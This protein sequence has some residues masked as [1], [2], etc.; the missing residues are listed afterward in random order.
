MEKIR[1]KKIDIPLSA[2]TIKGRPTD[3]DMRVLTPADKITVEVAAVDGSLDVAGQNDVKAVL[4]LTSYQKEGDMAK[5]QFQI[6]LPDGYELT[7]EVK[8]VVNDQ[9]AEDKRQQYGDFSCG[10]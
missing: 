9:K 7:S 10:G 6:T 8:I 5:F 2:I 1:T 3:L 4:D